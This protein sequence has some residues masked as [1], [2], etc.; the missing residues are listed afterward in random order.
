MDCRNLVIEIGK[1]KKPRLAWFIYCLII[2]V[3]ICLFIYFF[4]RKFHFY[5][6]LDLEMFQSLQFFRLILK[7]LEK[8]FSVL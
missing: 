8:C 4:F 2:F 1:M 7:K 6:C 5:F 3:S